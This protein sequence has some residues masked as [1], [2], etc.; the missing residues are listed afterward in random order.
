MF[1]LARGPQKAYAYVIEPK[2]G[3]FFK[4]ILRHEDKLTC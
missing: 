4:E 2:K 1:L 3:Q